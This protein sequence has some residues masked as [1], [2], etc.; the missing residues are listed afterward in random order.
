[1]KTNVFKYID[2]NSTRAGIEIM[3]DKF[4]GCKVAIIGLGGTGSYIRD[5]LAKTPV[6]EIHNYDGDDIALH[7]LF[8]APGAIDAS[9]L[10]ERTIKKVD[11]YQEIYSK[12]HTG[13]YA[14][15]YYVTPQ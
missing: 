1:M 10:D 8:R 5:L 15:P 4:H 13:I 12:M 3:N 6:L 11:Y 2:T 14:H 9:I 7:N